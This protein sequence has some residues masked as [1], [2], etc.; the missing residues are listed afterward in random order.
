MGSV[1]TKRGHCQP[2]GARG[3]DAVTLERCKASAEIFR[4]RTKTEYCGRR[5]LSINAYLQSYEETLLI[6]A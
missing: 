4:V 6:D 2:R 1:W 3:L 5:S